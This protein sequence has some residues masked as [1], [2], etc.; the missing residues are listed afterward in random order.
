MSEI[1]S[2]NSHKEKGDK[3]SNLWYEYTVK[4]KQLQKGRFKMSPLKTIHETSQIYKFLLNLSFALYFSKP[5]FRHIVEFIYGATQKGFSGKISDI[6]KLG[7]TLCH[8]TTYGKFLSQG[9]FNEKYVWTIIRKEADKTIKNQAHETKSPIFAIVDD[10]IS[11]KTKPSKKAINP[12]QGTAFHYSHLEDKIVWGHQILSTTLTC[13]DVVLPYNLEVYKR[14]GDS[15]IEKVCRMIELL[16][17]S[18][19]GYLLADNWFTCEDVINACFKKGYHYIGGLKTNRNIFPKGIC[20]QIKDFTQFIEKNDVDLVTVGNS[21]Y[22]V[23]RYEGSLKGIAH[24][25]VLLCWPENAFKQEKA[26][27]AFISTDDELPTKVIL[28]YYSKRW[29]IETFF[30]QTKGNL[31]LK[32]YQMRNETA[33]ERFLVLVALSY[34]YCVLANGKYVC[35]G[36]GIKRARETIECEQIAWIFDNVKNGASLETIYQHFKVAG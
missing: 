13:Q 6:V 23:Y 17:Q 34:L 7:K 27:R 36:K 14:G 11:K 16:P 10:T 35:F 1:A 25:A 18:S 5:V 29:P 32:S 3:K 9:K 4:K 22:W 28:E 21:S 8:R 33:I 19:Q 2:I 26:L 15:K 30:R 24:A 31:G 20:L 12:I